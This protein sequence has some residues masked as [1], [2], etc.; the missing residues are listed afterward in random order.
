MCVVTK[1]PD[2][3]SAMRKLFQS[4][5]ELLLAKPTC[6]DQN[7]FWHC[8]VPEV[9]LVPRCCFA[10]IS[11]HGARALVLSIL[12]PVNIRWPTFQIIWPTFNQHFFLLARLF[13]FLIDR[14]AHNIISIICFN[15]MLTQPSKSQA[16]L[17]P[18]WLRQGR[19]PACDLL[20]PVYWKY[21]VGRRTSDRLSISSK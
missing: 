15:H 16:E 7:Y 17:S 20:G 18:A 14:C 19:I 4:Q 13:H 6:G 5:R 12:R 2:V 10:M 9:I 1:F 21:V 8:S 11:Y 3:G